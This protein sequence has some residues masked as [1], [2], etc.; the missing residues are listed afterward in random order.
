M[1]DSALV[2]L[3]VPTRKTNLYE[4]KISPNITTLFFIFKNNFIRTRAWEFG[5]PYNRKTTE[6]FFKRL[7]KL[8]T[9]E[10]LLVLIKR[11]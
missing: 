5:L 4:S 6:L 11:V 7:G 1:A 8:R 3:N 9:L 10:F 2:K